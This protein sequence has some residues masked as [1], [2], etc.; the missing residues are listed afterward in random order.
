[1]IDDAAG[2]AIRFDDG[3]AYELFMGGWSRIAGRRFLNWLAPPP[4]VRWLELGCGTGAFTS[5]LNER[6]QPAEIISVDPAA[7]QIAYAR[8]LVCADHI[9]FHVASAEA[10]PCPDVWFDFAVSAL[11]INFMADRIAAM[12]EMRRVTRHGGTI[13][14]YVWDFASDRTPHGPLVR[15]LRRLGIAAPGPPGG[16]SCGLEALHLLFADAGLSHVET[17]AIAIEVSFTDFG[18]FWSAQRP[19]FSPTTRLIESLTST[20]R[21][22]LIDVLHAELPVQMDGSI[23]YTAQ[24][25]AVRGCV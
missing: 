18:E 5:V 11:A 10:L 21:R 1:M 24:A 17:S 13:A 7:E 15:A 23:A 12:R 19:S 22:Q 3:A 9:T 2:R 8:Q 4:G 25:N 6:C 14:A 16:D 20:Q